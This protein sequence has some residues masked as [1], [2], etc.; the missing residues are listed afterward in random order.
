MIQHS[1]QVVKGL[2]IYRTLHC[3]SDSSDGT[4]YDLGVL[5]H[6]VNSQFQDVVPNIHYMHSLAALTKMA[7]EASIL[8]G[9]NYKGHEMQNIHESMH[10]Q[11]VNVYVN[12]ANCH[13]LVL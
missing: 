8:I 11:V 2:Q 7:T 12:I 9:C 4:C 6:C 3:A 10:L 1:A 13:A 5:M